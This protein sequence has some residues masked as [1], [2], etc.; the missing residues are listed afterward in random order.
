MSFIL[1][2][3][4]ALRKI[5]IYVIRTDK[6][7]HFGAELFALKILRSNLTELY[8]VMNGERFKIMNGVRKRKYSP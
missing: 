7:K 5:R 4:E 2:E 6:N 8:K 3:I 1:K